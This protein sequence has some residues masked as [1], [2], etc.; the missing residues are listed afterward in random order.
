MS[1]VFYQ[2]LYMTD[3]PPRFDMMLNGVKE[4]KER[5]RQKTHG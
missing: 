5:K 2:E 3:V 4:S 1:A